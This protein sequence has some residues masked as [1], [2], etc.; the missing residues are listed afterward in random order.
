MTISP[1]SPW[2]AKGYTKNCF[3]FTKC[4]LDGLDKNIL[5]YPV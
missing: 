3:L 2:C 4:V 5:A 1:A